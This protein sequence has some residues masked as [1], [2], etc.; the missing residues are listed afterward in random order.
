MYFPRIVIPVAIIS[1]SLVD[2]VIGWVD[3]E[4]GRRLDGLLA[5]AT[6][7]ADTP[8]AAHSM[9]HGPRHR[10]ALAAFNAQYRDVKN[11]IG[12]FIQILMLATPVI[13]P[14]SRLP[15]SVQP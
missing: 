1:A 15:L 12:F 14:I 2:F 4:R 9:V 8:A 6:G 11:V 7:G 13:Y 3:P 5:L 10:P